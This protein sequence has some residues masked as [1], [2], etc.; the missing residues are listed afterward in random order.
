MKRFSHNCFVTMGSYDGVEI[1]ELLGLY[2]LDNLSNIIP[3]N[4]IGLYR[5]DGIAVIETRSGRTADKSR[6]EII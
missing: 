2:I 6:K 5:N 3:K 1:C 4:N